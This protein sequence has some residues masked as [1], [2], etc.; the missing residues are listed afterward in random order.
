MLLEFGLKN[1]KSYRKEA[2]FSMIP[3]QKQKGLDYSILEKKG[4]R[5]KYE[6]LCAAVVY[7]ANAS[8]KSN[9][10][11]AMETFKNI[12]RLGSIDPYLYSGL[13]QSS[14]NTGNPS[15]YFLR[16]FDSDENE[17]VNLSLKFLHEDHHFDYRLA[18]QLNSPKFF[19][20]E[21]RVVEEELYVDGVIVFERESGN[22]ITFGDHRGIKYLMNEN[23]GEFIT[24]NRE[25]KPM[26]TDVLVNE[27]DLFVSK[28]LKMFSPEI[29]RMMMDWVNHQFIVLFRSNLVE[30]SNVYLKDV[31]S[32][33]LNSILSQF[34]TTLKLKSES[35]EYVKQED[36]SH[37]LMSKVPDVSGHYTLGSDVYESYGTQRLAV[38]FPRI[39]D[40]LINGRTLIVDE[41]DTS[42]HPRALSEIIKVFH[43]D[44]LNQEKAQLIINTHNPILLRKDLFRRDEIYFVEAN[45]FGSE[46]FSL[47]DF[48]TSGD[49]GVRKNDDYMK[50]YLAGRYGGY[51]NVSFTN[52]IEQVLQMEASQKEL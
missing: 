16:N 52:Y 45:E 17:P 25:M 27:K 35:L 40:A 20:L 7:G 38:L 42:I 14:N 13:A 31:E 41:F 1:Y 18:L 6:A 30:V 11:S 50:N 4:G 33:R 48:G 46:L 21:N 34:A 28:Q 24:K 2:V 37:R 32:K 47:A 22:R 19:D 23:L 51:P 44:D 39:I 3:A 43:N 8:G 36:G 9:L 15:L 5:K 26:Y 10:F 49:H 29:S 12:L